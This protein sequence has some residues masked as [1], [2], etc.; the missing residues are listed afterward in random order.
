MRSWSIRV[1]KWDENAH[2]DHVQEFIRESFIQDIP[3]LERL[4]QYLILVLYEQKG[5]LNL[6][7]RLISYKLSFYDPCG[8]PSYTGIESLLNESNFL[9][10][11]AHI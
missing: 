11:L 10:L 8:S 1:H 3:I 9:E 2:L 5:N 6:L 7:L 4:V